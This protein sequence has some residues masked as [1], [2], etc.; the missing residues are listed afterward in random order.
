MGTT[1]ITVIINISQFWG[2]N[3][4][5]TVP[6]QA[7]RKDNI[8][9]KLPNAKILFFAPQSAIAQCRGPQRNEKFI[10][11]YNSLTVDGNWN[12]ENCVQYLYITALL[13]KEWTI[14]FSPAYSIFNI[15]LN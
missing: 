7:K 2:L 3:A 6:Q 15:K 1:F 10:I 5:P 13:E 14:Y 9:C 4:L 12:K 11:H 8:K